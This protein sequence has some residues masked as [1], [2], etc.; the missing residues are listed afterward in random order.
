MSSKSGGSQ[1]GGKTN[2]SDLDEQSGSRGNVYLSKTSLSKERDCR[3][4]GR[5]MDRHP[6]VAAFP[7]QLAQTRCTND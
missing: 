4:D 6:E 5:W 2:G 3:F 7:A 1:V